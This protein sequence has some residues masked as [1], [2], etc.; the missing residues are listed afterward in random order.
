MKPIKKSRKDID[1]T[2]LEEICQE[3]IDFVDNDEEFYEDNDY[4][5]YIS[6]RALQTIFGK[7]VWKFIND[8]I[9]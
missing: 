3:Y 9:E 8:K 7:D 2:E 4:D 1:L 6:E 5:E